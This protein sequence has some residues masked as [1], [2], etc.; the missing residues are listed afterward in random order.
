MYNVAWNPGETLSMVELEID[1]R[2]LDKSVTFQT[3]LRMGLEY[4]S[5]QSMGAGGEPAKPK[6]EPP[7]DMERRRMGTIPAAEDPD[8]ITVEDLDPKDTGE[9]QTQ[10][11]ASEKRDDPDAVV[12]SAAGVAKVEGSLSA[13]SGATSEAN[14]LIDNLSEGIPEA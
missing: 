10:A 12:A 5:D 9:D 13:A 7:E 8:T 11:R 2:Y 14:L 6:V 4:V 1:K 3:A